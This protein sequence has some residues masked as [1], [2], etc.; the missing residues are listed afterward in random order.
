MQVSTSASM[1][2]SDR[3][4]SHLAGFGENSSGTYRERA[5]EIAGRYKGRNKGQADVELLPSA[6]KAPPKSAW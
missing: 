6:P 2:A 3:F 4:W 1:S 5:D